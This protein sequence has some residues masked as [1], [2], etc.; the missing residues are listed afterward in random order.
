MIVILLG[1]C[2]L[3]TGWE[4]SVRLLLVVQTEGGGG[5]SVVTARLSYSLE[6]TLPLHVSLWEREWLRPPSPSLPP[7]LSLP[8][9]T[10]CFFF[11]FFNL[12]LALSQVFCTPFLHCGANPTQARL[13][14]LVLSSLSDMSE[15]ALDSRGGSH[16]GH[17]L[18]R[19]F[20]FPS[21]SPSCPPPHLSSPFQ[22]NRVFIWNRHRYSQVG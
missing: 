10:S 20:V 22:P 3:L 14:V 19:S 2:R 7:S 8:T 16:V 6:V 18:A 15:C 12:L 5:E 4:S 9:T 13:L 1:D 11:F 17:T 21:S